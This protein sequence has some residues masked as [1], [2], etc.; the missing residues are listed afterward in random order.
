MRSN[1]QAWLL[2]VLLCAAIVALVA[3]VKA[4]SGGR[5]RLP[6]VVAEGTD[7][8]PLLVI[9]DDGTA[10]RVVA[11]PTRILLANATVV[12]IVTE[13]VAPDRI[14]ALP[15]QALTWS[16]LVDVDLGFR[17]KAVFRTVEPEKIIALAPDVI[18][19]STF[20]QAF[21][22]DWLEST[23]IPIVNLPHPR[24]TAELS[25]AIELLG[26]VLD[27]EV[28]ADL[29]ADSL[30]RRVRALGEAAGRRRGLSGLI[31]SNLGAGGYA[32]GSATLADDMLRM[33]G[34]RN[35]A[36]DLGKR[37]YVPCTFEDIVV[38]NPDFIVVPGRFGEQ[39]VS[40]HDLLMAEPSLR[41]VTAI[42]RRQVVRLHP[43]L[44]STGSQEI[45]SAAEDLA[46][47]IDACL[48][49]EGSGR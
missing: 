48:A 33:V 16:R 24:G 7:R 38:A 10:Q 22:G 18:I 34:L 43:R 5:S 12:D 23:G 36:A 17:E 25:A 14:V 49:R 46:R 37:D 11:P 47:F 35:V 40:T 29:L 39:D 9:R 32:P 8:F 31:Y 20:N 41:E 28:A 6:S 30:A 4:R 21:A 1:W 19:S 27:A 13:L 3:T 26:R 2:P 15:E 44:F 42:A 45:V